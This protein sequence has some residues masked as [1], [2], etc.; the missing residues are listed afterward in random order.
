MGEVAG[1]GKMV[2]GAKVGE[3]GGKGGGRGEEGEGEEGEAG[4]EEAGLEGEG[5]VEEGAEK[6]WEGRKG[7]CAGRGKGFR[8]AA[9]AAVT[10]QCLASAG[11]DR[12]S[13]MGEWGGVS[14]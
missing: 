4:A 2:A 9:P 12:F 1:K 7:R 10:E 14:K 3:V 13:C 11:H 5:W 6:A 8:W